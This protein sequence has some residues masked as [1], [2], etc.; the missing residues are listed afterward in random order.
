MS[1]NDEYSSTHPQSNDKIPNHLVEFGCSYTS[2]AK[3]LKSQSNLQNS[4][5]Y[6]TERELC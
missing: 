4:Y 6:K 1:M 3:T 5:K 2:L